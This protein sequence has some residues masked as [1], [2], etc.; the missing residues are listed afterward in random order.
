MR[1]VEAIISAG[2]PVEFRGYYRRDSS[3]GVYQ[4]YNTRAQNERATKLMICLPFWKKPSCGGKSCERHYLNVRLGPS[5]TEWRLPKRLLGMCFEKMLTTLVSTL[6][7]RS[8]SADAIASISSRLA[9]NSARKS[10]VEPLRRSAKSLS[11]AML[12]AWCQPANILDRLQHWPQLSTVGIR[13]DEI[14]HPPQDRPLVG[15]EVARGPAAG[16]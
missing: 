16:R 6:E 14:D 8:N 13:L 12:I 3:R 4:K 9:L 10:P 11:A 5:L 7:D 2:V 1:F 15:I